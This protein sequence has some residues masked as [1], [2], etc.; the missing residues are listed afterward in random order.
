MGGLDGRERGVQMLEGQA[1]YPF[2]VALP[3][4]PDEFGVLHVCFGNL[5]G[6]ITGSRLDGL[7]GWDHR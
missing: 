5:W 7:P 4:Q 2:G 3:V 6:S 1:R